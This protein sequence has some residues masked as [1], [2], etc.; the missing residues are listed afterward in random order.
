MWFFI[1]GFLRGLILGLTI[2]FFS[3]C[4]LIFFFDFKVVGYFIVGYIV[5]RVVYLF[6]FE[7]WAVRGGILGKVWVFFIWG[8][9]RGLVWGLLFIVVLVL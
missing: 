2:R 6:D 7:L 5:S 4:V 8:G 3:R 9:G 1:I